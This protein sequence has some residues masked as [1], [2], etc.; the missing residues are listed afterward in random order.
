MR[1]TAYGIAMLVSLTGSLRAQTAA[2]P[3]APTQSMGAW[4]ASAWYSDRRPL[5]VG[6]P[7]TLLVAEDWLSRD[8]LEE[9]GEKGR[10]SGASAGGLGLGEASG[11]TG[12]SAR[13]NTLGTSR[14]DLG[15]EATLTGRVV[16]RD[17]AGW[18]T[19]EATRTLVLDK[20]RQV[21]TVRGV[22]RPDDVGAGNTVSAA[23]LANAELSLDGKPVATRQG[24]LGKL[25]GAL[26]P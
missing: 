22:I 6:E 1:W 16:E 5:L 19:V 7:V 20:R 18:L 11:S 4:S 14:R 8:R 24:L 12:I 25:V 15:L 9:R 13:S 3:P 21:L 26:W 10:E 17:P 23:R 2:P